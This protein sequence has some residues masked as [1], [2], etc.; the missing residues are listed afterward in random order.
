MG[1]AKLYFVTLPGDDTGGEEGRRRPEDATDTQEVGDV[2]CE[3]ETTTTE[4]ESEE[5]RRRQRRKTT[6]YDNTT[7]KID[8]VSARETGCTPLHK[9]CKVPEKKIDTIY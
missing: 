2:L 7:R 5:V 3:R 9:D 1:E 4:E 6:R 8:V